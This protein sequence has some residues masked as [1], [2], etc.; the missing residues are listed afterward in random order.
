MRQ[1][2]DRGTDMLE[3]YRAWLQVEYTA[4]LEAQRGMAVLTPAISSQLQRWFMQYDK[5]LKIP[6]ARHLYTP[7]LRISVLKKL[8]RRTQNRKQLPNE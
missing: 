8:P 1:G 7:E 6:G 3:R 2:R 4:V 5:Y